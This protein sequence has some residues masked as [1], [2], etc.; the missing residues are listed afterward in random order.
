MPYS[1]KATT[2]GNS[3]GFTVESALFRAHP[4]FSEGRFE[5][6]VIGPGTFLVRSLPEDTA[7]ADEADPVIDAWLSFID[8]DIQEHPEVLRPLDP[9]LVARMHELTDG[10]QVDLDEDLGEDAVIP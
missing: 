4:E 2:V 1:A 8:R 10:V 3:R 6:H 7:A 9:D 5:V